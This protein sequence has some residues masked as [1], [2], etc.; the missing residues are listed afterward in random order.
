[1]QNLKTQLWLSH[2]LLILLL[3]LVMAGAIV[4]FVRLGRSVDRILKDNY[5][6]VI[7]AQDMKEALERQDSATTFFL[8]GQAQK[9]RDQYQA[10]WT[11]FRDAF[12]IEAHNITEQ[13]EQ[14]IADDIGRQFTAY[15]QNVE[16]L[17]YARPAMPPEAARAYYLELW[18]RILRA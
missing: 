17:L 12:Q 7:A 11:R 16:R 3:V 1:M 6:S 14:Q 10:N 9:A 8:A 5:K 2:L 15:R 18:N 13:G 4:N